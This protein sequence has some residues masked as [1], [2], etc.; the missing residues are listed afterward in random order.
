MLRG[1]SDGSVELLGRTP[2][3]AGLEPSELREIA[4]A[5]KERTFAPGVPVTEEGRDGVGFFIIDSG[6]ARVSVGG[7]DVR[8]LGPGDHFGEVALIAG[9]PRTATITPVSELRCYGL[10]AWDFRGI[11]EANGVLA[12]KLLQSLAARLADAEARAS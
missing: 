12:W 7:T 11:V 2:L 3:F 6:I 1:V 8:T 10:S 4:K 9:R 5:L